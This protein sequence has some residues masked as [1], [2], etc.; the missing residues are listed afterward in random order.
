M[1]AARPRFAGSPLSLSRS[2]SLLF[3]PSVRRFHLLGSVGPDACCARCDC[4][5]F[6]PMRFARGEIRCDCCSFT[7]TDLV[8]F[9]L[10]RFF[11]YL[12]FPSQIS[13]EIRS[14]SRCNFPQFSAIFSVAKMK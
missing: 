3:L 7:L 12:F 14:E 8:F 9:P 13:D 1:S 5:T 11:L 10:P 4:V 2:F 6:D